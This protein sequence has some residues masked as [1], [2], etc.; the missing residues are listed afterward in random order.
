MQANTEFQCKSF[1]FQTAFTSSDVH[2]QTAIFNSGSTPIYEAAVSWV[3][4]TTISG[5]TTCVETAGPMKT[6]RTILI[7][8]MAYAGSP[9][10]GLAGSISVPLFTTGTECVDVDLVGKVSN[11]L[12]LSCAVYQLLRIYVD[13]VVFARVENGKITM[14][15]RYGNYDLNVFLEMIWYCLRLVRKRLE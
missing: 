10:S 2:I 7:Q 5:F 6:S 3:E 12:G 13:R 14:G 11:L 4:Q 9:D 15:L 8:W 1:G